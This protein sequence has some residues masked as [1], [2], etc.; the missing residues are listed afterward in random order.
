MRPLSCAV[1]VFAYNEEKTIVQ[2]LDS[3]QKSCEGTDTIIHVLANGCTDGT[4]RA[5]NR[6]AQTRRNVR[7]VAIELGDKANA[8]NHYV[9]VDAPQADVHFFVDGDVMIS[10]GALRNMTECLHR[11]PEASAAAGLPIS[12]RSRDSLREKLISNREMA[13]N[14]YALRGS[15]VDAFRRRDL[16]LPVGIFG[17]DGL[18]GM[19]VK[20]DLDPLEE[21]KPDR[22]APCEEG[23][24]YFD[25]L[26]IL[27]LSH[28]RIYRNRKMRYAIRRQQAN[29]LY[30]MLFAGG[31][32][33]MPRHVADMYR[34][35]ADVL[36]LRWNGTN[37][38][39]DFVAI[40]RIK[41]KIKLG[42]AARTLDEARY[43]S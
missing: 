38:Y 2:C 20:C 7:L 42:A 31:I 27:N 24:F 10:P 6:Y 35:R 41:R 15:T 32:G 40:Q 28:W 30:P 23:G 3:I 29:M 36:K 11:H 5:V 1:A 22:I 16:R 12:G 19:L 21:S 8:W 39:F 9:H 33:A 4:E 14:F 34:N 43:Y 25:S 13:G 18:V 17:E 26:S 37:T